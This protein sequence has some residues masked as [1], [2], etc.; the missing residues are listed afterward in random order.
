MFFIVLH[1]LIIV[2][3]GLGFFY[4]LTSLVDGQDSLKWVGGNNYLLGV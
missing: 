1:S 2:P 4:Y 3:V